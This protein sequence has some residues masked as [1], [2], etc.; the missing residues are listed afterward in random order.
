MIRKWPNQKE[1]P[2]PQTEGFK[3]LLRESLSEPEC[4]GGLV[5][6]GFKKLIG[7]NAFSF[8]VRKIITRYRRIGYNSNAMRQS[9]C[10]V[11]N[12]IMVD[13]YAVTGGSGVRLYDGPDI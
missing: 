8:Q 7:R 11:F 4:Y 3:P 5:Y 9:A 6:K 2:T 12:R 1:I 10:L 13:N